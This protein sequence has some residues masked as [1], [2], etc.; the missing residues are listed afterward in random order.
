LTTERQ[1]ASNRI[2]A[3]KAKGP[4]TKK[5][6]LRS[7]KNAFKHGLSLP[8]LHDAKLSKRTG[9]IARA[10]VQEDLSEQNFEAA[11]LAAE[12][13]LEIEKVREVHKSITNSAFV[14][15]SEIQ[16][17]QE[18]GVAQSPGSDEDSHWKEF[19]AYLVQLRRLSRYERRAGFR[20]RKAIKLVELGGM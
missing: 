19:G 8:V 4:K 10:M 20:W 15:L 16:K 14:H 2:N 9:A 6:K 7:S 12:A 11:C 18:G 1:I 3:R 17:M 13:Y 5:G